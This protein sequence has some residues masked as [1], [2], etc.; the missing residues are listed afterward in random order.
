M[1]NLTV[2][3]LRSYP[4]RENVVWQAVWHVPGSRRTGL[5]PGATFAVGLWMDRETLRL[6]HASDLVPP[7]E[8]TPEHLLLGMLRFAEEDPDGPHLPARVEVRDRELARALRPLLKEIGITV[9]TVRRMPWLEEA[10]ERLDEY[11]LDAGRRSLD[12]RL[13]FD[14]TAPS[15]LRDL[16]LAA[17]EFFLAAPW[18]RLEDA[19]L[20][21]VVDPPAPPGMACAMVV[22]RTGQARGLVFLPDADAHDAAMA[23]EEA[24]ARGGPR[25]AVSMVEAQEVLPD[26]LAYQEMHGVPRV[27]D[28][29][30]LHLLLSDRRG[31]L[32]PP[33]AAEVNH[34][35]GMLRAIARSTT[36]QMDAGEWS[37]TV[38]T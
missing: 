27:T 24:F 22:G 10:L 4:I 1:K 6:G 21:Q 32:R 5:V 19:D 16:A 18:L 2:E 14:A 3:R 33:T 8:A 13:A 30:F 37:V 28:T 34:M 17:R 31:R 23:D 11:L 36:D 15:R 35:E 38:D 25:A 12:T 7:E 9:R 26:E 20:I 29:R